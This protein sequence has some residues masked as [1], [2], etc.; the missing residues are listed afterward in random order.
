MF[1]VTTLYSCK[2]E[3]CT[4]EF[5]SITVTILNFDGTPAMLDELI[6][7]NQATSD[8]TAI[9]HN[10]DATYTLVDDNTPLGETE[11]FVLR[12]FVGNNLV[13]SEPYTFGKDEC[14]VEKIAGKSTISL[15]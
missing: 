5:K 2:D 7:I 3:G 4:D 8:T 15:D 13:L 10:G 1:F 6:L 12:G 11:N 9:S 14:H